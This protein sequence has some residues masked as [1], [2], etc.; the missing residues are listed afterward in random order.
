MFRMRQSEGMGH[1]LKGAAARRTP[2]S[3][4]LRRTI[5]AV[6]TTVL[7]LEPGAG[8]S[9]TARAQATA[10]VTRGPYLQLG[11]SHSVVVRWRTDVDADSRVVYGLQ[12]GSLSLTAAS[13][14]PAQDHEVTLQGLRPSTLYYYAVGTSTQ[15]LAGGGG[16]PFT[17]SP[18]AGSTGPM[19][20]WVLGDSGTAD[21]SASSVR[22]AYAAF[23]GGGRTDLWLMLGDN[24]YSNGTDSEYQAALFDM[25]PETLRTTVLWPTL[26]NH[27]ADSSDS[28]TQSGPY[29]SI[30]TLPKSGEGGG[31]ASGTEAYYSFDYGNVHFVCLD[32]SGSDRTP[33]GAMLRWLQQDLA[34]TNQTWIIS[35]WHHSS[36]SKGS[37][38][39]DSDSNMTDMREN[40]LPILEQGGVDL[41]MSGHS[42]D[43]ERSFLLDGHYG[44]SSSMTSAMKVDGGDGRIDGT[45]AYTKASPGP[46]KGAVYMVAGNAGHLGGG[47]LDH[48]AMFVSFDTMGS[49]V[50]DVK[51]LQ[52]DAR[53]LDSVGSVRDHFTMIK[54]SSLP[55]PPS[56]PSELVATALS[57]RQVALTWIDDASNETGFHVERCPGSGCTDFVRVADAP[58]NVA[59][60]MDES[61][62]PVTTYRYRVSAFN[63]VGESLPSNAS[64]VTTL[65]TPPVGTGDHDNDGVDDLTDNCPT[66]SN[67]SQRDSD[68]DAIGDA[69]EDPRV[70]A[71]FVNSGSS[72]HRIDGSDYF[73]LAHAFGTRIGDPRYDPI[74]DLN[75]DFRIDGGDLANL[76]MVWAESV[77]Q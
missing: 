47:S 30:F 6:V 38:D 59:R 8:P 39:S 54:G 60:Y 77:P 40:A 2:M 7:L 49:V 15:I 61:L 48:P 66:V 4:W 10:S 76:A 26:G 25:Y 53:F 56:G 72:A 45:G 73:E 44:A 62:N 1:A 51:G 36:Y 19:R 67:A 14:T 50:L 63:S 41:V 70:N 21:A 34:G 57:S 46:H 33:G 32:S 28:D 29:F 35:F 23:N 3:R 9:Q 5:P 74:V 64:T 18:S 71:D 68:A 13:A 58:A 43:Y 11:T 75:R 16:F 69:C 55:V 31:L 12:P 17:T 65:S 20:V 42:H 37:H 27:D 24:A 22:D 52:L